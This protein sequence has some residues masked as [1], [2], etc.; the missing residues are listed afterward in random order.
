MDREFEK[1]QNMIK[2]G[3]TLGINLNTM[4]AG[5]HV[6]EI[7]RR[8][9]VIK[10]QVQAEKSSQSS[11]PYTSNPTT[12]IVDL[13]SHIVTWLNDFLM[14]GGIPNHSPQ[15]LVHS[16]VLSFDQYWHCLFRAYVQTHEETNNITD[17]PRT[18]DVICLGTT[19]NSQGTY[20]FLNLATGCCIYRQKWTELPV[21]GWVIKRVNELGQNDKAERSLTFQN[22]HKEI[23]PDDNEDDP[24]GDNFNDDIISDDVMDINGNN[25]IHKEVDNNNNSKIIENKHNEIRQHIFT[26]HK[27]SNSGVTDT[28]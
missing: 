14:R 6:P 22:R 23:I 27:K 10:E 21:P 18:L 25:N 20:C 8:I 9:W 7:E 3:S 17:H 12:M 1:L 26:E 5:E 11:L 24:K 13:I 2:D 28:N 19:R 15:A 4:S 16:T